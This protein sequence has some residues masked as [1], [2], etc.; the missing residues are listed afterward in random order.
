M[1]MLQEIRRVLSEYG[2]TEEQIERLLSKAQMR[3]RLH[4]SVVR[5]INSLRSHGVKELNLQIHEDGN[6][7]ATLQT[8]DEVIELE[9]TVKTTTE[10]QGSQGSR[11]EWARVIEL[12]RKYGEPVSE[13]EKRAISWFA[14]NV[15]RRLRRKNPGIV[16]DPEYQELAQK[17][18]EKYPERVHVP[19]D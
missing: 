18:N 8:D 17:W 19:L 6:W 7:T 5:F 1:T 4:D 10:P 2:M 16:Y 3:S 15:L 9:G 11:S 13:N 12:A 14:G